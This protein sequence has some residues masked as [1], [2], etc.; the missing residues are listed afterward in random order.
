MSNDIY[1]KVIDNEEEGYSFDAVI[2]KVKEEIFDFYKGFDSNALSG[3]E[4]EGQQ[5]EVEASINKIYKTS[6]EKLV[7][8]MR[9]SIK[10]LD[11]IRS[12]YIPWNIRKDIKKYDNSGP[13]SSNSRAASSDDNKFLY[14]SYENAFMRS[15]GMPSS[16]VVTGSKSGF[17]HYMGLKASESNSSVILTKI[18]SERENVDIRSSKISSNIF[19][20]SSYFLKENLSSS[21]SKKELKILLTII[22]KYKIKWKEISKENDISLNVSSIQKR[23]EQET[24]ITSEFLLEFKKNNISGTDNEAVLYFEEEVLGRIGTSSLINVFNQMVSYSYLLFPPVYNEEISQCISEPSCIIKEPFSNIGPQIVN[25]SEARTSLLETIINIRLDKVTGLNY[26]KVNGV[27]VR[28]KVYK[29]QENSNPNSEEFTDASTK[30]ITFEDFIADR[31]PIESIIINRLFKS[32]K[33]SCLALANEI[34]N[35]IE[36]SAKRK[37]TLLSSET[38]FGEGKPKDGSK[39]SKSSQTNINYGDESAINANLQTYEEL[40]IVNDSLLFLI[41]NKENISGLEGSDSFGSKVREGAIFDSIMTAISFPGQQIDKNIEN[42]NK[43][44]KSL[45]K[46][47]RGPSDTA[48]KI[49]DIIGIY[50]GIGTI[51][52]LIFGLSMFLVSEDVLIGMLSS[53]GY[54]NLKKIKGQYSKDFFSFL[55]EKNESL[56]GVNRKDVQA[57]YL[58][59]FSRVAGDLYKYVESKEWAEFHNK[60]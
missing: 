49:D 36:K 42:I 47:K 7:K 38:K 45:S 57:G 44:L 53:R 8:S 40:K 12:K 23:S 19:N 54:E 33:S 5:S 46:D 13:F 24:I 59:Q 51:D 56:Y 9:S 39:K 11:S 6:G 41:S 25:L 35:L 20:V 16:S 28:K 29:L 58:L 22:K 60:G 17:F 15:L 18:L 14:E 30:S 34:E 10:E 4:G 27:L 31:S 48:D 1:N 55:D 37:Q 21:L 3:K 50:R 26:D 43:K 52:V 2:N 32:L